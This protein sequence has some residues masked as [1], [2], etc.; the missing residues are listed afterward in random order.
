MR[1]ESVISFY[2]SLTDIRRQT[3]LVILHGEHEIL[4][5]RLWIGP[6]LINWRRAPFFSAH[7]DR[8]KKFYNDSTSGYNL[9]VKIIVKRIIERHIDWL[10]VI[11]H[12]RSESCIVRS[13][14]FVSDCRAIHLSDICNVC[15]MYYK[16][17]VS[18]NPPTIISS[19][20]KS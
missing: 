8:R 10:N 1:C 4:L 19:A 6:T 12:G 9:I 2:W 5:H 13:I 14:E 11:R 7:F 17:Q 20:K 18:R 15:I 16:V 3:V